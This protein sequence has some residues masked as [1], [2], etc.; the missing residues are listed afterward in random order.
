VHSALN[1]FRLAAATLFASSPPPASTALSAEACKSYNQ[2]NAPGFSNTSLHSIPG[3]S[4]TNAFAA[5]SVLG[6]DRPLNP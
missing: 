3:V 6:N 1:V 4:F 2:S 5:L